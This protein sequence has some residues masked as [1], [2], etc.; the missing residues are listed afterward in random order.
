MHGKVFGIIDLGTGDD[1]FFG[2]NNAETVIDN[3]GA[4]TYTLGGG[5]DQFLAVNHTNNGID[6]IDGGT[7][8]DMYVAADSTSGVIINLSTAAQI[9]NFHVGP[10]V[11]LAA[12]T[13]IGDEIGTDIVKAF[14]NAAGGSGNDII[15]GTDGATA[16]N[17][18]L[19]NEGDDDL[20]GLGGA[21]TLIGGD[22]NDGLLGGVGKDV[23]T[24]GDG[25]T[26][27]GMTDYFVYSSLGDSGVTAST[28]DI[29]TDFELGIDVI[30]LH[31][32]DANTTS[33]HTG[34]DAFTFIGT[35][36]FFSHTAG[37]LRAY[38]S[39]SGQI[40]EG[41]VNGDG[42]ADFSIQLNNLAPGDVFQSTDFAL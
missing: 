41:D 40:V 11:N 36:A 26:F 38:W 32:I 18:I 17:Y 19:G 24:G 23:L 29:I 5:D 39:M 6:T 15:V 2:G 21:D 20:A 10:V 13:A 35:N 33:G 27:D 37:E 7:G 34:D 28:R 12:S 9:D 31:L 4:D 16:A 8:L 30:D 14:E 3:D 22:G 25:N 42:R 1:K